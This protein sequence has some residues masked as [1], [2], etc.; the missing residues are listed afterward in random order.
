MSTVDIYDQSAPKKAANL[1]VNSELL[2]IAKEM[3]INLSRTLEEKLSEIVRERKRKQWLEENR[4]AIESYNA[5]VEKYGL[6]SDGLRR[7]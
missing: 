2:A 5:R 1:S 7:F 6:F 3:K 4:E